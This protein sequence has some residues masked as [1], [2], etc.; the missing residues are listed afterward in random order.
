VLTVLDPLERATSP[1][2]HEVREHLLAPADG[3]PPYIVTRDQGGPTVAVI[4]PADAAVDPGRFF[5]RYTFTDGTAWLA[6]LAGASFVGVAFD[7]ATLIVPTGVLPGPPGPPGPHPSIVPTAVPRTIVVPPD[8]TAE[9]TVHPSAGTSPAGTI[10]DDGANVT[11]TPPATAVFALDPSGNSLTDL[12]DAAASAYGSPLAFSGG[13]AS[14]AVDA[15]EWVARYANVTGTLDCSAPVSSVFVTAGSGAVSAGEWRLPTRTGPPDQLPAADAGRL[16]VHV[17]TGLSARWGSTADV[18]PLV[19]AHLVVSTG[20]LRLAASYT[21]TRPVVDTYEL[22][23][24]GT[25]DHPHPA[26]ITVQA[27][28][29]GTVTSTQSPAGDIVTTAG[30][31]VLA[32]IDRPCLVDG[33]TPALDHLSVQATTGVSAKGQA[34]ALIGAGPPLP[35]GT[36]SYLLENGLLATSGVVELL[37][38]ATLS[39]VQATDATFVL[40]STANMLTPTLPNP[41]AASPN[42]STQL[43]RTL[44]A[45]VSWTVPSSPQVVFELLGGPAPA[46]PPGFAG[47]AIEESFVVLYDVSG[48]DDQFGV[49]LT[50][51]ALQS[52]KVDEVALTV[53]GQS[54]AL[55][56]LPQIAWEAVISEDTP[57]DRRIFNAIAPDDGSFMVMNVSTQALRPMSPAAFIERYLADYAA[58][59]DLFANFTLP[60]G[61]DANVSTQGTSAAVRPTLTREAPDFGTLTGGAQLSLAAPAT[62][63]VR[64]LLPGRSDLADATYTP[65]IL[66]ADIATFWDQQFSTGLPGIGPFVPVDR[67]ALSGY[68]TSTFSDYVD[69][70]IGVGVVE[71][72]FDVVIGRTSFALVQIRSLLCPWGAVVVN[73]TIFQRDGAGWVQRRST[74]WRAK[75]PATFTFAS[76]PPPELGGVASVLNIRNIVEH[77]T[78]VPAGG[79]DWV[80][81]SFDADVALTTTG[82]NALVVTGGDI[83]LGRV[84]GTRFTGWI[85]LTASTLPPDITDV[86]A[87][88]DTVHDAAGTVTGEVVAGAQG[89]PETGIR[90]TLTG[91]DVQATNIGP[92]TLG[93]ALRG[94][95]HLPRD[96]SWSVARRSSSQVTPR[97]VDP[98]TPVPLV[99]ARSDP[100]IWHLADPADV[101]SLGSP[102]NLYSFVQSTGT[103]QVLFEHPVITAT[104]GQ[105]PLNFKQPPALADVGALL[106]SGGLI[107]EL[108]SMLQLGAFTGFVPS[109][110]GL[111]TTQTLNQTR[112]IADTTLIPLGPISVVL[113]TAAGTQSVIT[114]VIDPTKTPRWSI[115][116][117]NVAFKLLVDGM[118]SSTDPLVA[119]TGDIEAADGQKPTVTNLGF[120]Y[121]SALGTVQN[122]LAGI[123]VLAQALPGGYAGLDV[124]FTGTKLRIRDAVSLPQL[125]LGLGYLEG[126][127]LD[128]GFEL[129]ILAKT[130]RFDVGVGSDLDPFT[131]LASP[132]AGNGLLQ[133][134]AGDGGLGVRLQGG[135]GVGLGIDL[136]IASGSASVCIAAQLDTTKTPFGIML[137]LTGNASVDVLDG[138]ASASLTLTAGLGIQVSPGPLSDL[139]DVPP[140]L[141]HF[142]ANSSVTLSAEVAVAIH[143]SVAWVV[144]VDWSG[145]WGFSETI[146]GGALTSLLP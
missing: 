25:P 136:A 9:L 76:G 2:L 36:E 26:T 42:A 18:R 101:S 16:G 109:G 44:L 140:R 126:I 74:G 11:I 13:L 22:W 117:T 6:G 103:Q 118:G 115:T 40:A 120:A 86:L 107:P 129:D 87:L 51:Q 72:R 97:P 84:A 7:T 105:N 39:G 45:G 94:L 145:Q 19:D 82:P 12:G 99:R 71:A 21:A 80:E 112:T 123:E 38:V 31:R 59:A 55:F 113:A 137:L 37:L 110:D 62:P 32:R 146:S 144:H 127:G 58:G 78:H 93:V 53:A 52:A 142:I 4:L 138:L 65:A 134:G 5:D 96:G 132:L 81:V 73:T 92:R 122:V 119:V 85:D 111:A 98:M 54:S 50:R 77:P 90:L 33:T 124:S 102:A 108:G 49:A 20:Q 133:L 61:L 89:G 23:D 121:G 131:W 75:T 139:T 64:Q 60:F 63:F 8:H 114:V 69:E 79:K 41:Y 30:C 95:P 28:T 34:L 14:T 143:L 29:Q 141:E 3:P 17:A 130:M 100:S 88:M 91:V 66:N 47:R 116:V 35:Q 27:P 56:A 10:V 128:L 48:A 67:I 15:G 1:F 68:G 24:A 70:T 106:G 57:G 104:P 135:I 83:G 125:P 46:G 43:G